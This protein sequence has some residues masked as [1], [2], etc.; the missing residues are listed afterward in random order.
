MGATSANNRSFLAREQ[1]LRRSFVAIHDDRMPHLSGPPILRRKTTPPVSS[2][3]VPSLPFRTSKEDDQRQKTHETS[4]ARKFRRRSSP[5]TTDD[6]QEMAMKLENEKRRQERISNSNKPVRRASD[7]EERSRGFRKDYILGDS[8]RSP[9][10]MIMDPAIQAIGSLQKYD[11]AFIKRS[12]GSY[13]YAILAFRSFM[14]NKR[15]TGTEECMTFVMKENGSTKVI[16]KKNWSEFVHPVSL[17]EPRCQAA[18]VAQRTNVATPKC[19]SS[20]EEQ[21]TQTP[22]LR[23]EVSDESKDLVPGMVS[24]DS[25]KASEDECSLISSVSDRAMILARRM[26]S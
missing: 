17:E 5:I 16:R 13:S 20:T 25:R 4:Y 11:F 2:E 26:Q 6:A 7:S 15:G 10:H 22:V 14:P 3:D 1:S 23:Q 18:P 8:V 12:D 24:F 9:S 21:P 19:M